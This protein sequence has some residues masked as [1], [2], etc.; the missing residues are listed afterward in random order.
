M[1]GAVQG[2]TEFLPIS[3]SG[4]LVLFQH[5][6][7]LNDDMLAFDVIVHLATLTV[8]FVY[9]FKD[10]FLIV[11]DTCLF[12]IK[13]PFQKNADMLFRT[14]P[15]ALPGCFSLVA[16][17]VTGLLA[18]I[19]KE[20]LE[21]TFDHLPVVGICWLMTGAFL[22]MSRNFQHGDRNLFEMNHQDAF[23]IGFIQAVAI[24]PGISRSGATILMGMFLGLQR[25]AAAKFSF[26]I[27]IPAILGAAVLEGREALPLLA[28]HSGPVLLGFVAAA[29]S[30]FLCISLLM[31][32]IRIEK[33]FCFGFYCLAIGILTVTYTLIQFAIS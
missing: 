26:L 7:K 21:S 2:L 18:Y 3:S 23:L 1:L 15:Y 17:V 24:L 9:F 27:A 6:M 25:E 11:R 14:H 16:T 22:V 13:F 4:H 31:K 12:L 19:F 32:L 33:F 20:T 10:I 8:V 29:V 28:D 5:F 30:G